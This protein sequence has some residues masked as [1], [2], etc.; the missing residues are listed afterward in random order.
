MNRRHFVSYLGS[1]AALM[2]WTR[3]S[4]AMPAIEI[5][6]PRVVC[7]LDSMNE[8]IA[9]WPCAKHAS[10]C[11][12][13]KTA[14]GRTIEHIE[15]AWGAAFDISDLDVNALVYGDYGL[16]TAESIRLVRQCAGYPRAYRSL[17]QYAARSIYGAAMAAEGADVYWRIK[18]EDDVGLDFEM[19]EISP[20]GPDYDGVTGLRGKKVLTHGLIKF[21]CRFSFDTDRYKMLHDPREWHQADMADFPRVSL[22]AEVKP[23]GQPIQIS[24]RS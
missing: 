24:P 22:W 9:S 8:W 7:D 10:I 12:I 4:L 17:Y 6:D 11:A 13:E 19:T 3:G 18:P 5:P 21:Y 14:S 23:E 16:L 2:G 15:L 20:D 1:L